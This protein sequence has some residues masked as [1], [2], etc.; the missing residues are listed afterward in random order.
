MNKEFPCDKCGCCCKRLDLVDEMKDFDRGDGVCKYL[1]PNNEC[2]IYDNRPDMCNT[3][4]Y[5]EKN[6][7]NK[8]TWEEF[9]TNCRKGCKALQEMSK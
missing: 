8:M 7:K 9:V 1:T 6:Y 4:K 2:A 3:K 5:Y